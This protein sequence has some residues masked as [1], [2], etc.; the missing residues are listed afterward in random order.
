MVSQLQALIASMRHCTSL[1]PA[2]QPPLQGYPTGDHF[3]HQ[4]C[5]KAGKLGLQMPCL[6]RVMAP[7]ACSLVASPPPPS[8][9]LEPCRPIDLARPPLHHTAA[10]RPRPPLLQPPPTRMQGQKPHQ[11]PQNQLQHSPCGASSCSQGPTPPLAPPLPPPLL[12]PPLTSSCRQRP[13]PP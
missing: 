1:R 2:H 12:L 3:E 13:C 7:A 11:L 8:K 4:H 9:K 5:S 10:R 6:K